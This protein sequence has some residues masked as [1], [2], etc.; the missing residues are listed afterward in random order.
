MRWIVFLAVVCLCRCSY[1]QIVEVAAFTVKPAKVL[2]P[3]FHRSGRNWTD[4]DVGRWSVETITRHLKGEIESP[5]HRGKVPLDQLEGRSLME[6]IAIH[7]NLHEGYQ[8]NGT[9]YPRK[10]EPYC[11]T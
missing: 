8:W 6:L 3:V 10:A 7:A 11:P 2:Q 9:A 4:P 1:S 5:Q